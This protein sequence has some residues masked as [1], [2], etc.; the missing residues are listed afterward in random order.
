MSYGLVQVLLIERWC[1]LQRLVWKDEKRSGERKRGSSR[2]EGV[3]GGVVSI[4][5]EGVEV[6]R[7]NVSVRARMSGL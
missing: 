3:A 6:G 5:S 7:I 1:Y 2:K 4:S